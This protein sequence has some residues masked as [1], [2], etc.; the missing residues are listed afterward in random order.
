MERKYAISDR[1]TG[2]MIR[3]A[4]E[5]LGLDRRE[6]ASFANCSLRTLER[7]E[8]EDAEVTGPV[9]TLIELLI[10]DRFIPKRLEIPPCEL[11]LRLIYRKGFCICTVIDVDEPRREVRI[12]NYVKDPLLM[13]FGVNQL[14]TYEEYEEFLE[15]RCFPKTR[16]KIKLELKRLDL[17]FYDPLM[18][19]EKT[20]GRMAEDDFWIEIV[21]SEE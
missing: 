21:R 4:R 17:P 19:I 1:L 2:T 12:R 3:Q 6:F 16:D 13:A 18:I 15:S 7:W 10:R 8:R 14:P 9:V 20:E 11:R 5:N